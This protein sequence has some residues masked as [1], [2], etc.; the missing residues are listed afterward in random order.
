MHVCR[1]LG[2][3]IV[4]SHTHHGKDMQLRLPGSHV[5]ALKKLIRINITVMFLNRNSNIREKRRERERERERERK[6]E[7][8]RESSYQIIYKYTHTSVFKLLV[9][10]DV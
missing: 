7:R 8:E 3:Y 6:R 4:H 10:K 2:L 5:Y 9:N 1:G